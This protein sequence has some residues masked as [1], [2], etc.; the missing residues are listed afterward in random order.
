MFAQNFAFTPVSL[1]SFARGY[2]EAVAR[3]LCPRTSLIARGPGGDIAGFVLVYPDY[4]ALANQAAGSERVTPSALTFDE[5]APVL[6]KRG[7]RTGIVRTIAVAPAHRGRGLS[8][9][10]GAAVVASGSAHYDRW[11]GA[12]IRE[13]NISRRFGDTQQ[14]TI[15]RYA[16]YAADLDGN[17]S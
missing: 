16:L 7:V 11:I 4:A 12:L 5:H 6:E 15:R 1:E 8:H 14:H 10:L 2:G 17:E 13:D 9:A 3:R